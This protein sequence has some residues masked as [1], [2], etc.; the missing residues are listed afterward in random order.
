MPL[1]FCNCYIITHLSRSAKL[2]KNRVLIVS[3]FF[4]VLGNA[5]LATGRQEELSREEFIRME[6]LERMS[7]E[8]REVTIQHEKLESAYH[9]LQAAANRNIK[10]MGREQDDRTPQELVEAM[11]SSVADMEALS[12]KLQSQMQAGRRPGATPATM[13][14]R[15]DMN[16]I[17]QGDG[18]ITP[19]E[20]DEL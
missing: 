1:K 17:K 20:F 12:A 7:P 10:Y 4:L 11:K 16:L 3:A 8:Q 6:N 9:D 15:N 14:R 13:Y 5:S 18:I 2:M 19:K